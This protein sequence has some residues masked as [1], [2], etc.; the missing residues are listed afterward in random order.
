VR[1]EAPV[2]VRSHRVEIRRALEP[3]GHDHVAETRSEALDRAGA[4]PREAAQAL[5]RDGVA[6]VQGKALE[7]LGPHFDLAR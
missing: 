7:G 5:P 2:D 6:D 1:P 3:H 4:R